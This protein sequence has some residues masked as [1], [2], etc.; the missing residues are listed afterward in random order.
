MKVF[1]D[2]LAYK[3]DTFVGGHLTNIGTRQDVGITKELTMDVYNTVK[4]IHNN[5]DP[6][7]ATAEAVKAIG[8]DNEFLLFKVLL[9]KGTSASV[10]DLQPRGIDRLAAG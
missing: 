1:D 2:F 6:A 7:A 8:T 5:M 3:F 4:R 9:D 10:K